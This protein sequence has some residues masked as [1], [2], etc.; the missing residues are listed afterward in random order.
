MGPIHAHLNIKQ[1]VR[2]IARVLQRS[3]VT[4]YRGSSTGARIGAGA[5]V[6]RTASSPAKGLPPGSEN[7]RNFGQWARYGRSFHAI[8]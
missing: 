3:K 8:R 1:P 6:P 2:E 7:G 5:M 4:I